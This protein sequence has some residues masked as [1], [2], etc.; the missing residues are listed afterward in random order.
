M[1]TF[2][3]RILIEGEWIPPTIEIV[4][5]WFKTEYSNYDESIPCTESALSC[6]KNCNLLTLTFRNQI[7]V[8]RFNP[9]PTNENI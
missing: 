8:C 3:W 1:Q 5:K 2:R 7:K 6:F 4:P 9:P